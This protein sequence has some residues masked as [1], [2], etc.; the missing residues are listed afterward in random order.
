LLAKKKSL[1]LRRFSKCS[2]S[3]ILF[4]MKTTLIYAAALIAAGTLVAACGS[5]DEDGDNGASAISGQITIKVAGGDTLDIDT[6]KLDLGSEGGVVYSAAYANGEFTI[7]FSGAGAVSDEY[8][9]PIT[10]GMPDGVAVSNA[11]VKIGDAYLPA[12][13][14][15]NEVGS[16]SYGTAEW[17]GFLMYANG[18]ANIT[19]TGVD[20]GVPTTFN[21]KLKKGWNFVYG[22]G[23]EYA[24]EIT[25]QAPAGAT[26]MYRD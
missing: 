12:Y 26:W 13:K 2:I 22:K 1:P 3:K 17:G 25:T 11:N 15:G 21:V 8:L 24:Y 16:F 9:G 5:K 19:G 10:Q 7:D 4:K 23:T 14:S 6:V 18:D 20:N